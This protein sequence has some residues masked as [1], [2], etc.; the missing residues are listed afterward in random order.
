MKFYVATRKK[1]YDNLAQTTLLVF[2]DKEI[3][4]DVS[5]EYQ[6]LAGKVFFT[7][8]WMMDTFEVVA[9]GQARRFVFAEKISRLTWKT[10]KIKQKKILLR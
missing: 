3:V 7:C 10:R 9:E 6:D 8:D 1:S 2:D 4:L 5:G